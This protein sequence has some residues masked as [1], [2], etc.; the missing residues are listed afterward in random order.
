M[1]DRLAAGLKF[2]EDGLLVVLLSSMIL[3]A[4]YQV[5]ARNFFDTGILW[6]DGMVRVLVLWVTFVGRDHRLAQ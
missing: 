2:I 6:G 3:V 1:I 5:I 4:A